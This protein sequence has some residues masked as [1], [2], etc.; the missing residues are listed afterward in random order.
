[1][2]KHHR[3]CEPERLD[4]DDRGVEV[5]RI[6]AEFESTDEDVAIGHN[7]KSRS[8]LQQKGLDERE[9]VFFFVLGSPRVMHTFFSRSQ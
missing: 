9:K 8:D 7:E 1:M 3:D 6:Q 4:V 5:R 2:R